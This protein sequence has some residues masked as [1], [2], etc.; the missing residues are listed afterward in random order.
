LPFTVAGAATF[1]CDPDAAADP[2]L[3]PGPPLLRER[4]EEARRHGAEPEPPGEAELVIHVGPGES[5]KARIHVD[6]YEWQSY[7]GTGP[8]RLPDD[9]GRAIAVG[10]LAAA[11]RAAAQAFRQLLTD[12]LPG[13]TT[14]ESSYWS[15]LSYE[16]GET[17][18]ADPE[19][20]IPHHV[21]AVLVGAGSI[22]GAAAYLFARTPELE[23]YLDIV[24]PQPLEERNPDR[25]LLATQAAAAAGAV[26]LRLISPLRHSNTCRSTAA[27]TR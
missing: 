15:A 21:E 27:R 17:P 9:D 1:V 19:L 5:E 8:S 26:K 14:I 18:F 16:K 20:S 7:V 3:P 4:L 22:G 25:A 2:L 23:G 6:G 13:V 11:C 24:D 10:P 12:L